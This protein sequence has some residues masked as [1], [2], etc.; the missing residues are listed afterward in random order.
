MI[1]LFAGAPLIV[2]A[3]GATLLMLA[4]AW[5]RNG[6]MSAAIALAT[7]VLALLALLLVPKQ[8]QSVAGLLRVDGYFVFTAAIVLLASVAVTLFSR[9]YVGGLAGVPQD[10]YY[11]LLLIATVGALILLCSA[12]FAA[13]FLGLETLSV[14]LLGLIAYPR[15]RPDAVEAGMKYLILAGG[16]SAF[17]VFGIALIYAS[18]GSLAFVG[19]QAAPG[20][21][22]W[23][24]AGIA[25]LLVGLGTKLSIVPFHMWAPDI[26][27]GAPA[28]ISAYVAVVSKVAVFAVMLR[29]F[30]TGGGYGDGAALSAVTLFAVLSMLGGNLLALRQDNLKRLLAY[31]SIAH[32]GYLL[33]AF[34]SPGQGGIAA[35]SYYLAAYAVTTLG[36]FGVVCVMSEER[37]GEDAASLQAYR[38][39]FW[40][41]P[42]LAATLTLML[43]SLAGIPPTMGFIGKAYVM[44]AGVGSGLGLPVAALVLGSIVGLYYYLRVVVAMTLP[45]LP[46]TTTHLAGG[47]GF[48]ARG[49]LA[50]LVILLVALG[51]YPSALIGP[52]VRNPPG[53]GGTPGTQAMAVPHLRDDQRVADAQW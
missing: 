41:R 19:A 10:E 12:N 28:P 15:Q 21:A 23:R 49:A 9:R 24:A 32:L 46:A 11:L 20:M 36:A 53:G 17:L 8:P 1:L 25:L 38:G 13:F 3:L 2:L 48:P 5:R 6:A 22:V 37:G 33:V 50:V 16:G 40:T 44:A 14:A 43:L 52:S 31:S 35:S 7:F 45:A 47:S 34:L 18:S 51:L 39:L 42:G 30:A 26:Y 4:I 27:D 29:F